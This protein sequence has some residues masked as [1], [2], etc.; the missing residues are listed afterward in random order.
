MGSRWMVCKCGVGAVLM[1]LVLIGC[2]GSQPAAAS[3]SASTGGADTGSAAAG[4]GASS[5]PSQSGGTRVEYINDPSLGMNAIAVTIPANWQFQ[6]VFLQGGTCAS[7]PFGVFRATRPDGMSMV[8]RMPN[9]AWAWGQ[10]PMIGYM[11]KTDC[12]PMRGPLSA[13]DFLKY[14]AMTMKV[15]YDGDAPVPAAEQEK[16]DKVLSDAQATY[17]PKYAASH[18]QM[19]KQTQ[20]LA[21]AWVSN[22]KGTT[23]MKGL[24]DVNVMCLETQYAGQP[25]LT[26]GSP[27]HPPQMMTGTPS[28]VD[29]CTASVQYY[30]A[31]S[32]QIEAVVR[33]W[34]AP[35]MGTKPI[36]AWVQA[37]I[38]RNNEQ[39][40]RAIA[41]MNERSRQQ[42]EINHEQ[43]EHSMAVQQQVHEQF[44]QGMQQNFDHY[45]QGVAANMAA[46][47]ASTSD[48]VDFALDR[49]TVLNTNTG[50]VYKIS[51][52]YSVESPEEKLHGNGTPWN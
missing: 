47:D 9:L 41:E 29:K 21:R 7:T 30:T 15:R 18:L 50:Q 45:Q 4:D 19:P 32:G 20:Q 33:Q 49:Q 43:F 3:A 6:S 34:D 27:G 5:A 17:G 36:D 42:M 52:Q 44:M 1:A 37:W 14:M 25:G 38:Q 23:P 13:Q 24:L 40:Q 46:R 31:P 48:W 16:A 2:K 51:N 10:G 8:E 12:L 39:S 35:G 26:Q 22:M 11:P 28:V